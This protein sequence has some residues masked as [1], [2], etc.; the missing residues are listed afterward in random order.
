MA[1]YSALLADESVRNRFFSKINQSSDCWLWFGNLNQRG[2]GRFVVKHGKVAAA[3]RASWEIHNGEIPEGLFVCHKC[4]NP[5]CVNPSHLFLGTPQDN[6]A[7]A[8]KKGRLK[9]VTRKRPSGLKY[10]P[11]SIN[12]RN[13]RLKIKSDELLKVKA[14]S[15]RGWK[16][17]EIAAEL[18]VNYITIWKILSGRYVAA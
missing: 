15:K 16:P 13:R 5:Q 12:S 2:Y 3:H 14:L 18:D 17:S 8:M 9:G 6:I 10:K 4:D 1:T 11:Q 7:D